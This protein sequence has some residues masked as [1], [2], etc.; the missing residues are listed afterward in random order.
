MTTVWL[1]SIAISLPIVVGLNNAPDGTRNPEECRFN[2][3][4]FIIYSSVVSFYL[5]AAAMMYLYYKIFKVIRERSKKNKTKIKLN[6]MPKSKS[7]KK[8]VNNTIMETDPVNTSK[9]IVRVLSNEKNMHLIEN[10]ISTDS[11][12]TMKKDSN[13]LPTTKK[14]SQS[15]V[16]TI[17]N[18]SSAK[19]R[20]VT[21]TLSIVIC[22]F[23][24]CW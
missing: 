11:A 8:T 18:A 12:Q 17:L 16:K 23:L 13:N 15:Q 14:I 20:K 7:D 3:P 2:N 22:L 1:V 4:S 9:T 10:G 6:K 21:I 19:E 24:F 5:P